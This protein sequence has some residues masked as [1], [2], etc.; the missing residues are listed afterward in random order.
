MAETLKRITPEETLADYEKANLK[1]AQGSWFPEDGCACGLGAKF[2]AAGFK[3]EDISFSRYID[4][5]YGI[6]Y[7]VGFAHGFDGDSM[8]GSNSRRIEGYDDG[9]ACWE[10]VK[11]LANESEVVE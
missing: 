5:M 10:A 2:I 6:E 1:P 4:E 9:Q 7:R 11:H 3:R 8:Q